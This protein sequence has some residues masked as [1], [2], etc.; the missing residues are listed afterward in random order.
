MAKAVG[1]FRESGPDAEGEPSLTEQNRAFIDFCRREGFEVGATFLDTYAADDAGFRQMLDYLRE[2]DDGAVV[3]VD[4]L[5]RLGRDM[6]RTARAYFQLDGL[7]IRVI[8]LDGELSATESLI[9]S[10]TARDS[11][12]R[13]G[14]RVR[15]AM[16]QKA[17][18][19]EVLGRAPYG[20]GVG[21]KHRLE[22]I[23]EEAALIRYMFRLY[24]RESL[25]IRLVARRLNEEGYRTRRGGN[26]SMVT[27]RDILRNRAYL[28][29]YSRFGVRVPGSHPALITADDYRRA[30]ERMSRRRTAGGKRAMNPFLLSGLA[31]CGYCGNRLIGVSRHQSWR[32]SGDGTN[33]QAE[34]R[35]YQCE[36]R[37]NQSMCD[38]H[39]RRAAEFEEEVRAAVAME[40]LRHLDG[41]LDHCE[42]D[43]A[44][45]VKSLK[46]RLRTL[47][48]RL[49]QLLD[50]G[51]QGTLP[52]SKVR[53]QSVEVAQQ[54][55]TIEEAVTDLH[56]RAGSPQNDEQRRAAQ[57]GL[58][59]ALTPE[60]W[61][62]MDFPHRQQLLAQILQRVVSFDDSIQIVLRNV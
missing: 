53:E 50:A 61:A 58:L 13:A 29:T 44:Q 47:D 42:I 28:G 20:Y 57:R 36:T 10:W 32:R 18:R 2:T 33:I 38:Y 39:T 5:N 9:A 34:Y 43:V 22:P 19:G 3:V 37:T 56:R 1:Y 7:G 30:Q 8:T 59:Q 31:Y 25:G 41:P 51:S 49:E 45:D 4:S 17:I 16:R 12:E 46:S 55:L 24:N 14:E 27:I 62:M 6:R 48:R 40:V 11:S 35:Y 15:A 52:A 60:E 21:D 23:R 26:W 54:Q